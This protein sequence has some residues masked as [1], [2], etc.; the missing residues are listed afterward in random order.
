MWSSAL[1]K[2]PR[3]C[4]ATGAFYLPDRSRPAALL[5]GSKLGSSPMLSA[6]YVIDRLANLV[7]CL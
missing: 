1:L 7:L 5:Q 2:G 3:T 6:K 4:T